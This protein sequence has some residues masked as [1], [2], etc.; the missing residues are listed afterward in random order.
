MYPL[1]GDRDEEEFRRDNRVVLAARAMDSTSGRIYLSPN[2]TPARIIELA[3]QQTISIRRHGGAPRRRL[4]VVG[5]ALGVVVLLLGSVIGVK[6]LQDRPLSGASRP[7][8]MS[9]YAGDG[10][11]LPAGPQLRALADAAGRLG[12]STPGPVTYIRVETWSLD[13]TSP[14][15]NPAV[16]DEQL[17]WKADH[18]GVRTVTQLPRWY[19][20]ADALSGANLLGKPAGET[21]FRPGELTVVVDQPSDDPPLLAAQLNEHQPLSDGPQ[22]VLRAVRDLWRYHSLDGIGRSAALHVLADTPGLVFRG[23]VQVDNGGVGTLISADSDGG[24]VRDLAVFANDD[25]RLLAYQQ[26]STRRPGSSATVEP[27]VTYAMTVLVTGTTNA[28]GSRTVGAS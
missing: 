28:I 23:L 12:H 5:A 25:G 18:S 21:T 8:P 6:V 11:I 24:G 1:T 19:T 13:T 7:S 27:Y 16:Q 22:A 4:R 14:S 2:L 3:E 10:T 17:W 26:V 9:I 15:S 20:Y